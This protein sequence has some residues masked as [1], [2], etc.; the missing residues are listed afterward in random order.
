[1]VVSSRIARLLANAVLLVFVVYLAV[2]VARLTWLWVWSETPVPQL[3]GSASPHEGERGNRWAGASIAGYQFF[4]RPNQAA[5][6]AQSVSRSAPETRLRLSLEGIL[7]A[8]QPENS[9][10]IVAG[11]NGETAYYRVGDILPGNAELAEVEPGRVLLR[12]NGR[13][14][15]LAFDDQ[16]DTETMVTQES[17]QIAESP[18][19]FLASARN[20]IEN[21]GVAAL[22]AYGLQP[23]SQPGQSGYVYDGSN[24]MLNAVN[25]RA[26][27]VITAVNGQRLGDIEQDRT[28]LENWR[29][30]PRLDIEIERNGAILSVSYAIPEQWR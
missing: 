27:D 17:V 6:V 7:V 19:D 1:M 5:P 11:S 12:R 25:L 9:G 22:A 24:P 3:Y 2:E 13:Y 16:L 21:Q 8:A 26:G 18:D 10:A 29:S 15:S 28:L 4:G 30:S 23:A 20:Q 14:E